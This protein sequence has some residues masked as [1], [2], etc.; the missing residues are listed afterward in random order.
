[1]GVVDSARRVVSNAAWLIAV[2]FVT[3]VQPL[4]LLPIEQQLPITLMLVMIGLFLR[5]PFLT[6]SE[7][8]RVAVRVLNIVVDG[9]FVIGAVVV[10]GY[11]AIHFR[12][13]IFRQGAFTAQDLLYSYIAVLLVL[14]GVRRSVGWP[15]TMVCLTALAYALYGRYMPGALMHRGYSAGRVAQQLTLSYAGIYGIPLQVMLRYVILFIV[16]GALL[17]VSGAADFLVTFAKSFAG[18]YTGGLGKVAVVASAL[19]GSIS[20]SAAGNVATTGSVTIPAM[21][22]AGYE[23]HFAA[24]VESVASTGGQIMPPVMGA[25][26][27]LMADYLGIPYVRVATAAIIPALFYFLSAGAAIDLY[28]RANGIHGLPKNEVPRIWPVVRSGWIYLFLIVLV[29]GLLIAGYSAT[30]AAFAGVIAAAAL[31]LFKRVGLR[32]AFEALSSGAESAAT[33]CAVTAGAGIV[34]GVVQLT[35]I[36][37]QLAGVLVEMSMGNVIFL[38]VLVMVASIVLGMGM[39]TTVVYVLLAALVAPALVQLGI[40][41]LGAHFFFFY[42]GVLAAITPP[43][44]LAS[45]AAA[46][47]AGSPFDKTGWAAFKIALPAFIVPFFFV[48]NPALLLDGTPLKILHSTVTAGLGIWLFAVGLMNYLNGRLPLWARAVFIG[49]ALLLIAGD[50]ITDAIGFVVLAAMLVYRFKQNSPKGA[51]PPL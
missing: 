30:L 33:L 7:T 12:A 16:F 31:A 27:F 51:L 41:P 40:T 2:L 6:Q 48:L 50:W 39:P 19:V 14:E 32:G 25:A 8:T 13:I 36:G 23:P 1:M 38:L 5:R 49:I 24:A 37:A 9:T 26:A 43:V 44:A 45:Y 34:V 29:Y 15:L 17:Q 28:A 11:I 10:G 21:K 35:G 42:F 3:I 18:R 22:K 47:I 46:S 20:G 4:Y